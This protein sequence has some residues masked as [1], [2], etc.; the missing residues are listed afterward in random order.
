MASA[1]EW[2]GPDSHRSDWNRENTGLPAAGVHPH[3]WAACV[4][5]EKPYF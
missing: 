2:R 3:G 5:V 4:S 1:T